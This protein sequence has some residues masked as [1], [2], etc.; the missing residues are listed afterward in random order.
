MAADIF[1]LLLAL[2]A[3]SVPFSWFIARYRYG[4]DLRATGDGNVGS[5]NLMHLGGLPSVIIA[6]I[7]DILKGA[8]AVAIALAMTNDEWVA[9]ATGALVV[10]GHVFPP[11]LAFHGGR[12]AA[13]AVG[14]AWALFPIAGVA[15]FGVG[16]VFLMAMRS[17]VPA[18][19]A[20]VITLVAV[21]FATDG[22]LSRLLFVALLF[23]TVGL[24]DGFDRLHA[25]RASR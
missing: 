8:A 17:T 25:S 24:K 5:G 3:G 21:V 11:W 19:A 4:V 10:V 6:T 14:V 12:G 22:D 13:P 16:F 7:L 2:V 23:I 20:A 18:I 1:A 9:L 15:M